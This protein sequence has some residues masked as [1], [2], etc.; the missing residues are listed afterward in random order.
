MTLLF[1]QEAIECVT[2]DGMTIDGMAID[3]M[4]IDGMAIDDIGNKNLR[5][6]RQ[7]RKCKID[8][9]TAQHNNHYYL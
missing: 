4:A 6:P 8:H 3:G 5:H 7:E 9:L 1:K 2:I